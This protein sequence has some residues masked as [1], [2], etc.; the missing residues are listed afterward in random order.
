[1][2]EVMPLNN[3]IAQLHAELGIPETYARTCAMTFHEDC[4]SLVD[5]GSDVFD[6]EVLMAAPAYKAW[7]A[8]QAAAS[9]D[10][11]VLQIVSAFRSA[12]YQAN[13]LRKK[14]ER[15]DTIEDILKVNAAPGF[16]EHHTG[17]A[18]DITTPGYDA[19]EESFEKSPAFDWLKV[20]AS[21]FGFGLSFP[22]GNAAGIAY[23]PWHWKYSG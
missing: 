20:N 5:A 21:R 10:D 13:L 8:M 22:R 18:L 9:E 6:R 3:T 7:L 4:A 16:S 1:M 23:E 12:Q 15:G 11:I 19:L 14:L 2:S 17:C